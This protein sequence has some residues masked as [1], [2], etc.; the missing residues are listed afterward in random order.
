MENLKNLLIVDDTPENIDILFSILRDKYEIR[1]AKN[2]KSALELINKELPDLILLDIMMPIMDGYEVCKKL[3]SNKTTQEIPIIFLSAKAETADIVKGFQLGAVDY[4]TKPFNPLELEVRV[5]THLDFRTTQQELKKSKNEITA[6][7]NQTFTGFI[8]AL[9]DFIF[10]KSPLLYSRSMR[11]NKYTKELCKYLNIK[12][13]WQYEI[14]AIL[15][16]IGLVFLPCELIDK[17]CMNKSLTESEETSKND[18]IRI[19]TELLLKIPKTKSIAEMILQK[20]D[21]NITE[22][23]TS[24]DI[25]DRNNIEFGRHLLKLIIDFDDLILENQSRE[26]AINI[27]SR[28]KKNYD[29]CL[30]EAFK[31]SSKVTESEMISRIIN[32]NQFTEEMILDKNLLNKDETLILPKNTELSPVILTKIKQLVENNNIEGKW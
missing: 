10:N 14:A 15:S 31:Q 29:S 19:G 13:S 22:E 1:V 12:N 17:I 8:K 18:C 6:L 20:S 25:V 23:F 4:L 2:G 26:N 7:L 5:K 32:V 16:Q 27:L 11:L 3:K 21:I 9:I 24:K 28:N 30:L